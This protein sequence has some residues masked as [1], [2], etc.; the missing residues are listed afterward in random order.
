M[1]KLLGRNNKSVCTLSGCVSVCFELSLPFSNWI[2]NIHNCWIIPQPIL[3]FL[4]NVMYRPWVHFITSSYSWHCP[5]NGVSFNGQYTL[6]YFLQ[7]LLV[8]VSFKEGISVL[9]QQNSL[10][11]CGIKEKVKV[12]QRRNPLIL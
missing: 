6:P 7:P 3:F 12:K 11:L 2:K 4:I 5:C 9:S 10:S 8:G 1:S